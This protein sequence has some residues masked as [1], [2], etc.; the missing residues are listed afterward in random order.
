[1]AGARRY[2]VDQLSDGFG[3]FVRAGQ[4]IAHVKSP[5]QD[6]EVIDTPQ[7]GRALR[8]DGL[9]MTSEHDE[10]FYHESMVHMGA[11]A[12]PAPRRVLIVG[13]GDG[14]A[15]EE[16]LKYRSVERVVL[17][18]LDR[19]VIEVSREHLPSIHRG[20]FSDPRLTLEIGDG[21]LYVAQNRDAFDMIMLDLTDPFGAA[22]ALYSVEF[23]RECRRA[24][25]EQGVMSMHLGSPIIRP[26]VFYRVTS[27]LRTVFRVVRPYVVYV[28]LYGTWWGMAVASDTVDPLAISEEQVE[29]RIAERGLRDLKFY[30]GAMHRGLLALPNFVREILARPL[31][32]ISATDPLGE[33]D[34]DPS[35]LPRLAIVEE[36]DQDA[37]PG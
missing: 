20:A 12:H 34:L 11:V 29:R 6:I 15:A 28:P 18:E 8:I 24:L 27:S 5:Y 23:L 33:P 3:F 22:E 31:R 16:F 25:G 2:L 17:A 21:R 36:T 1:M 26:N 13:G 19:D 7:F 9:F 30:N 14:G 4:R 32:P 10:F 35:R 37:N